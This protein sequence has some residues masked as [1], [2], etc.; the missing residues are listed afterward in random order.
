MRS[1]GISTRR[2]SDG[3]A[4]GSG[5]RPTSRRSCRSAPATCSRCWDPP[6]PASPGSSRSSSRARTRP[7]TFCAPA[8]CT[9]ARTSPTGLCRDPARDRRRARRVIGTS[10]AETQLA[11][12]RLLE[13]R[14]ADR[15]QIVVLDDIQWAEPVFLDLIEH[16]AD[17]SRDAPI[18]LLCVARPDLLERAAGL[19]RRQAE[20][21]HDPR[22]SRSRRR[23]ARRSS[24]PWRPTSTFLR[25]PG[26]GS[27]PRPAATRSSSRRWS[28]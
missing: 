4:S 17:W 11:F 27:S 18:F 22:S 5:S 1:R 8:A 19:G 26:R 2:S 3:C 10:P 13:A 24:T 21:D 23:T 12:R 9:T 28:R 7:P 20:R 15:P 16:V 14:A 25:R 6:A